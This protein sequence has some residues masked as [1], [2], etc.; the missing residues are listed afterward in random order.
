MFLW[1]QTTFI[2]F[3]WFSSTENEINNWTSHSYQTTDSA[4]GQRVRNS[5]AKEPYQ[6]EVNI[7]T[8]RDKSF[9]RSVA[10][11]SLQFLL[12]FLTRWTCWSLKSFCSTLILTLEVKFLVKVETELTKIVPG[13]IIGWF[14]L[15]ISAALA[16]IMM[17]AL[18]GM[19]AADCEDIE[20][21][22]DEVEDRKHV[23]NAGNCSTVKTSE[24]T[25]WLQRNLIK[26]QFYFSHHC[27]T[28]C[29]VHRL[30]YW[31][32]HLT[33]FHSSHENGTIGVKTLKSSS[34]KLFPFLFQ[35]NFRRVIGMLIWLIVGAILTV[36][37]AE[38]SSKTILFDVFMLVI[39]L[40]SIAIVYSLY[41]VFKAEA[42]IGFSAQYQQSI[43]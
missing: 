29:Y 13:L 4:F 25:F 26:T 7:K 31:R 2:R 16:L 27:Y 42:D 12:F 33:N 1:S 37:T 21:Y 35:R 41:C 9:S 32:C 23:I 6:R 19:T 17:L 3:N 8:E 18:L 22:L 43:A 38:F 20:K 34:T 28:L 15:I 24:S 5:L 30:A 14:N 36:L 40:Y 39:D 10:S 11:K